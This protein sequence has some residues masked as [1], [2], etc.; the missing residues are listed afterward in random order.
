ML[1]SIIFILIITSLTG[2][3]IDYIF[4]GYIYRYFAEN[5]YKINKSKM[6]M[7]SF[8]SLIPIYNLFF[9]TELILEFNR[10][11]HKRADYFRMKNGTIPLNKEEEY[12]YNQKPSIFRA[13]EI[14]SNNHKDSSLNLSYMNENKLNTIYYVI[15]NGNYIVT[16]VEGPDNK[17]SLL[18]KRAK[19]LDE[20]EIIKICKEIQK[21]N[22]M[23]LH[24]TSDEM[25]L[26]RKKTY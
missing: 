10:T 20:I 7:N 25:K 1:A 15:E 16:K 14:N 12:F 22:E 9:L 2:K 3:L 11:K 21:Q 5:G 19:L 6:K 18:E 8:K 24:K 17:L 26:E 13:Y 4:I 23:D